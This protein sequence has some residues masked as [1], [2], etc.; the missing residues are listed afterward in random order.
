MTERK[1]IAVSGPVS[2]GQDPKV[3]GPVRAG[4]LEACTEKLACEGFLYRMAMGESPA[5]T[6]ARL[7]A[8][9]KKKVDSAKRE[10]LMIRSVEAQLAPKIKEAKKSITII[11][12]GGKPGEMYTSDGNDY[13]YMGKKIQKESIGDIIFIW[14]V[15]ARKLVEHDL[16]CQILE[17]RK[18]GKVKEAAKLEKQLKY[19]V[20]Y[21][22]GFRGLEGGGRPEGKAVDYAVDGFD[23]YI[24]RS[25]REYKG[26]QSKCDYSAE[27]HS[28]VLRLNS[29]FFSGTGFGSTYYR[30]KKIL[31]ATFDSR[32]LPVSAM[33]GEKGEAEKITAEYFL[34][35][36]KPLPVI[37]EGEIMSG[38]VKLD[39]DGSV[40]VDGQKIGKYDWGS[41]KYILYSKDGERTGY[42]LHD[43]MGFALVDPNGNRSLGSS[44]YKTEE[45]I[46]GGRD[47]ILFETDGDEIFR[48]TYNFSVKDAIERNLLEEESLKIAFLSTFGTSGLTDD[49]FMNTDITIIYT[50]DGELIGFTIRSVDLPLPYFITPRV[51][52][53]N[54]DGSRTYVAEI[55][56]RGQYH[57]II[58]K[59]ENG[60]KI[61]IGSYATYNLPEGM[62]EC[63]L[64]MGPP[65]EHG[66]P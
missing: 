12:G 20:E 32:A 38:L 40:I 58:I 16:T 21:K 28:L 27:I 30:D 13:Y 14:N 63:G 24:Y 41:F 7:D 5:D 60:N 64:P 45:N 44:T 61:E 50:P 18:P 37:T 10:E 48:G 59:D 3:V 4:Y 23:A 54:E 26:P 36:G 34:K 31:I 19:L 55:E 22:M 53:E 8:A 47:F 62:V 46:D 1:S 51:Y 29:M 65:G 42:Y 35:K 66:N 56:V 43:H 6:K 33:V 9:E 25:G 17:L 2:E 49:D 57:P 11:P 52:I 39:C 15:L